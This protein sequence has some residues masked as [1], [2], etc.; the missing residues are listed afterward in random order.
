MN[1]MKWMI[2]AAL[3]AALC[4]WSCYK[5]YHPGKSDSEWAADNEACQKSVWEGIR[6]DPGRYTYDH[7][8]EM[9]LVRECMEEKG[10][11]WKRTDMFRSKSESE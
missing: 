2:M 1:P 6:D 7:F 8:D 9:R 10:W 3:A 4:L 5:P 11:K